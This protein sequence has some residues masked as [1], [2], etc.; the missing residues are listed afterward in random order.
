[1]EPGLKANV[2][3]I[4]YFGRRYDQ[5]IKELKEILEKDPEFSTAH[6]GLG[7]AYEQKKM[8]SEAIAEF[9]KAGGFEGSGPNIV[10]SMAAMSNLMIT[11]CV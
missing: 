5:A 8:Y 7:L 2:G 10:A 3:V 11:R 9:E 4:N 1:L 6:W